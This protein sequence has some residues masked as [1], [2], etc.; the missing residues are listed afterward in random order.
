MVVVVLALLV[1]G[2][3]V[4]VSNMLLFS[5]Y[6][7]VTDCGLCGSL[8]LCQQLCYHTRRETSLTV[9][10]SVELSVVLSVLDITLVFAVLNR[11]ASLQLWMMASVEK[12]VK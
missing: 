8:E 12:L 10:L 11:C 4:L 5:A 7:R 9:V 2:N 3:K 1:L 6:F